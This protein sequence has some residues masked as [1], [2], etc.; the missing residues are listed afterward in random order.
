MIYIY[1]YIIYVHIHLEC[2]WNAGVGQIGNSNIV[3]E[4][5]NEK[6]DP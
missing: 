6:D 1:V 3:H 5:F 2:C 4:R